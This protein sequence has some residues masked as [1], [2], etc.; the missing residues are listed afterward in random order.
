MLIFCTFAFCVRSE[1]AHWGKKGY[2][3][4]LG[5]SEVCHLGFAPPTLPV[6]WGA[7]ILFFF[8]GQAVGQEQILV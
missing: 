3:H 1:A 4:S 8:F 6:L 2:F 7:W 5:A